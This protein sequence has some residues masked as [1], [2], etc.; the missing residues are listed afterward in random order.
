MICRSYI[1]IETYHGRVSG[2]EAIDHIREDLVMEALLPEIRE[3]L[4]PATKG[5]PSHGNLFISV[6]LVIKCSIP[7]NRHQLKIYA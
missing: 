3:N 1:Q 5:H 6:Y 2:K 7:F 4:G